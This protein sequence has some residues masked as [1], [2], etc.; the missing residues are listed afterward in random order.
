MSDDDLPVG[1]R[2]S[3]VPIETAA[4]TDDLQPT[5]AAAFAE[6]DAEAPPAA[7][8]E[9]RAADQM[10]EVEV[11]IRSRARRSAPAEQ[12]L[13]DIAAGTV[14]LVADNLRRM[15]E[16][17]V[18][19]LLPLLRQV[20]LRDYLDPAFW[21]GI[22]MVVQYQVDELVAFIKRRQRGE[23][24]TDEFGMDR[25]IVELARPFMTFMY[26]TWWRTEVHGLEHVPATGRALL[27]AN[28]SGVLPW[29]GAMIAAAVM[30]DH[31][32]QNRR[33]VR[34]LHL[35]WFTTLPF[36]A[37]TLAASPK[38]SRVSVSSIPNAISSPASAAAASFRPL[39]AP[40]PRLCPSPS[41]APK[42]SIPCSPTPN[43]LPARSGCP[44][45]R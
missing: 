30:E 27:T 3:A 9:Y 10:Y 5:P 20:D 38:A 34:T 1:R 31:P 14:K 28:H 19:R 8:A 11:D 43:L 36:V 13:G 25:Q 39:C 22:G 32:A 35:H 6:A 24:T 42:R 15:T 16:E 7:P 17:Q 45:F 37:P 33:V 23:Y 18:A 12:A 29:D 44:S 4:E 2:R 40:R 41:S 26:R 21:Q